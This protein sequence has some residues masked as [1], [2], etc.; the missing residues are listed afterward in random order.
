MV[1]NRPSSI[2][3]ALCDRFGVDKETALKKSNGKGRSIDSVEVRHLYGYIGNHILKTSSIELGKYIQ[4]DHTTILH[5]KRLVQS[6]LKENKDGYIQKMESI[7]SDFGIEGPRNFS[8][9]LEPLYD[10]LLAD[11]MQ[12]KRENKKL[13]SENETLKKKLKGYLDIV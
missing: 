3:K 6:W 1:D 8:N 12:L 11:Y 10:S 13:N 9:P 2:L 5:S 7:L 4:R